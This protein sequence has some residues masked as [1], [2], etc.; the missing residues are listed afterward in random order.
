M[1][2]PYAQHVGDRNPVELLTTTLEE[3]RDA[4]ALLAEASWNQPW[5]PGKWTMR[6]VMVH[7]AQW[8]MIFGYRVMC[9]LATPG[10]TIQMADQD[11]L[12]LHT[13]GIDGATGFAAFDGS[14]RLN[15]GVIQPLSATERAT[16]VNHPE[17]GALTVNDL[18][19]QMAGHGI[20][21]LKQIREA[22]GPKAGIV[23]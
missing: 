2:V 1:T 13:A 18:I 19:V 10:F 4:A 21:H 9:A 15:I 11:R 22:L 20:H 16:E 17:Y 23:D 5:A 8:E 12:L 6:Q 7:V 3:Y 14:R